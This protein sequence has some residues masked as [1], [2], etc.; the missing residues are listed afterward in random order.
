MTART[1]PLSAIFAALVALVCAG[2][3]QS[4]QRPL[5]PGSSPKATAACGAAAEAAAPTADVERVV[6]GAGALG[7]CVVDTVGL[8]HLFLNW[9]AREGDA[10]GR[11]CVDPEIVASSWT[12]S[13]DTTTLTPGSYEVTMVAIDLAG[14]R[15]EFTQAYRVEAPAAPNAEPAQPA[16]PGP[17]EPVTPDEPV[18]PLEPVQPAAP[19]TPEP[20]APSP[21][22]TSALDEQLAACAQLELAPGVL[23]DR[24]LSL[25][26]L[27]CVRPALE[28]LGAAELT[29]DEIPVPPAIVL[30]FADAY[31][32]AAADELLPERIGGVGLELELA[33]QGLAT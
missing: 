11:I 4:A 24:S 28:A 3:A 33:D 32:L 16:E 13:W 30:R 21:L 29:L 20:T 27:D 17:V 5:A 9:R 10:S 19:T 2:P 8:A 18:E 23:A 26:V 15:G 14:N 12:C 6:R 22:E 7:G 1:L 31:A 25:A